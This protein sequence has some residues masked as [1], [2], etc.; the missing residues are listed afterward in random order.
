VRLPGGKLAGLLLAMAAWMGF[1]GARPCGAG[2]APFP[3][4]PGEPIEVLNVDPPTPEA[5]KETWL[6]VS[7]RGFCEDNTKIE[8][9]IQ[10]G[11][12]GKVKADDVRVQSPERLRAKFPATVPAGGA[13]VVVRN[14]D[15]SS[16]TLARAVYFREAGGGFSMQATLYRL[17]R[18]WRGF[19]EWFKLGGPVMYPLALISFFGL[20]W[21]IHCILVLRR[22]QVVPQQFMDALSGHL[23]RGD[24]RGAASAAERSGCVFAKVVLAG[25]R[26]AGEAPEKIR[27][28]IAAAGSR[29]AAHL[30]QKIHYLANVGT[31]APMLGLLGTVFGMVTGFNVIASGEVRQYLLAAAIAEAMITTVA[32]LLIGIPAMTVYFYLRGRLLRLTTH[33]E[34]VAEEVTQT[35]IEK[36]EEA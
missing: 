3:G 20:G 24:L 21:M 23:S 33:M 14:P 29:E 35:I 13:A 1:L 18:S 19:L 27:E 8:V 11:E 4:A 15:G 2:S 36:G 17:R 5:G 22:S 25:L 32:G 28:A 7:G 6:T 26:K 12:K 34:A 9:F 31:I 16:A 10:H 30:H